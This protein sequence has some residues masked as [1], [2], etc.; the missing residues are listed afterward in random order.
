MQTQEL[1]LDFLNIAKAAALEAGKLL[2][3]MIDSVEIREK[4]ARDLVTDADVASQELIR[5][6][7]LSRFPDHRFIGEEDKFLADSVDDEAMYWVVDPLDGTTNYAHGMPNYAVSIAL[8][9]RQKVVVG[10]VYDPSTEELYWASIGG[11]AYRNGLRIDV[12]QE[13]KLDHALI[14]VSLPPTVSRNSDEVQQFLT[15]MER[16]QSL[17][18][19]GSAALNLCYIACGRLDGYWAMSTRSWDIAAGALICAEAGASLRS[20]DGGPFQVW[21]GSL[22]VAATPML[23]DELAACLN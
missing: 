9:H 1:C 12:S 13:V 21:H 2:L 22:M 23:L 4:G 10:V 19:L 18:R 11:G 7:L 14:A 8:I 16:C 5:S 17:R 6:R 20:L 15:V 3:E